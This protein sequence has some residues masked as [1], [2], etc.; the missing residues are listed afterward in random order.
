MEVEGLS[1]SKP[2]ITDS[3]NI[4]VRNTQY[5]TSFLYKDRQ[6]QDA[7]VR[8]CV[9]CS[10]S[11]KNHDPVSKISKC[12]HM[13]HTECYA[14]HFAVSDDDDRL[15]NIKIVASA[16]PRETFLTWTTK[17]LSNS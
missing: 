16:M 14:E 4:L 8:K 11:F 15:R 7:S 2:F 12:G 17:E 10:G 13:Y 3:M 1:P 9:K 5:S 6:A